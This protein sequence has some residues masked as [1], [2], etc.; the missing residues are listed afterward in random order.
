MRKLLLLIFSI[1]CI[2]PTVNAN[3]FDFSFDR[4]QFKYA[5]SQIKKNNDVNINHLK[6]YPLY[7]YLAHKKLTNNFSKKSPQEIKQFIDENT[8]SRLA[9]D[10][11][12]RWI[13]R[14][15]SNQQWD[16]INDIYDAERA[17]TASQCYYLSARYHTQSSTTN[18]IKQATDLWMSAKSRPKA[19]DFIFKKLIKSKRISKNDIWN[20]LELAMDKRNHKLARTLVKYLP[21]D[22]IKI[23]KQYINAFKR[24]KQAIKSKH[25]GKG[26]YSRKVL[27]YAIKRITQRNYK[28]GAKFWQ[29]YKNKAPFTRAERYTIESYLGLRA[30][31]NLDPSAFKQLNRIPAHYRSN[32][33]NIWLARMALRE[34][35]WKTLLT[36]IENLNPES[37]E[38]ETWIYWKARAQEKLGKSSIAKQSYRS[39][40]NNASFH[41]FLA[42]DLLDKEY[43]VFDNQQHDWEKEIKAIR[44][45][46]AITRAI[47]WFHQGNNTLAFKEW[48]WAIAHMEKEDVLAAAALAL[49]LE[50][51]V[52]AVRTVA[53]VKDW[54]Q[55]NLRFPLLYKD[56][57]Q[58]IS[59]KNEV[60]PAWV[61]GIM[62]RESIFNKTARSSANAH[63]LM[64]LLPSTARHVGR[65]MGINRVTKNDL[66]TPKVNINLGSA[67]LGNMLSKFD[68][69]YAKAT[70]GYNAGP[71]RSKRWTPEQTIEADRWIDSIPFK[72][73]R[74]YVRAVMAYTTIYDHK[75]TFGNEKRMSQQLPPIIGT[76]SK[77]SE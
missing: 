61:Y 6:N 27:R 20:R 53:K 32:E 24:P 25:V 36:T 44:K 9:D 76:L 43:H 47:E 73:T 62:R 68:G 19:C 41:G 40:A 12:Q 42:A 64:Q 31:F 63:G 14:L 13:K 22:E 8:P 23:A 77:D 50:K 72:E 16:K 45:N 29:R 58:K 56:L 35:K 11:W 39:L 28:E 48:L 46:P 4:L 51:T 59:E 55:I 57:I 65:K 18:S 38:E 15:A 5:L 66:F 30:A 2:S 52:L 1:F 21:N 37:Q 60:D 7:P 67:Y 75:L 34:G 69:S 33:A 3:S 54:N 71:N 49:K 17:N 70:A 74:H 10:V 26:F